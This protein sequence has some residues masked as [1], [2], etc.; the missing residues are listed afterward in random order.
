MDIAAAYRCTRP[1]M[2]EFSGIVTTEPSYFFG[3]R[4]HCEHERFGVTTKVGPLEIID[5][6]ALAPNVPVHAGDRIDVRGEMGTI[7]AV[8]RSFTGRITIPI[9]GMPTASFAS[10]GRCMHSALERQQLGNRHEAVSGVFELLDDQPGRRDVGR[11]VA[12]VRVDMRLR[13]EHAAIAVV[14][15]HDRAVTNVR[16]NSRCDNAGRRV[17]PIVCKRNGPHNRSVPQTARFI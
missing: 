8:C 1:A 15:H 16:N 4:T 2:V 11:T 12:D 10:R 17:F 3:S 5:N 13:A 7:V 9:T 14:E 6:I